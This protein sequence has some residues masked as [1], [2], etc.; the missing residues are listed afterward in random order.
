MSANGNVITILMA[1]DDEDDRMFAL[2]A[3]DEARLAN[4]VDF[5]EDGEELMEYLH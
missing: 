5:V 4:Q 2:D 3:L 1:D